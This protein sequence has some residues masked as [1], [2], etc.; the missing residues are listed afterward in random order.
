MLFDGSIFLER[1]PSLFYRLLLFSQSK[2]LMSPENSTRKVN[3]RLK[4]QE[5][6]DIVLSSYGPVGKGDKC[7]ALFTLFLLFVI[8]L[9][10]LPHP[11]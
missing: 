3:T 11:L 4:C 8:L 9:S 1:G 10:F 5:I 2:K 6:N 7:L